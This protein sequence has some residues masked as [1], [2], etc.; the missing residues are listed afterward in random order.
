LK[1]IA[2]RLLVLFVFASCLFADDLSCGG[3][4]AGTWQ[5]FGTGPY[6]AI[7]HSQN[8]KVLVIFCLDYND[9]IAPPYD[10]KANI[11]PVTPTNVT[12]FAQFGGNYGQG[13]TAAPWAFNGD[14]GVGA[15][16][17]VSLAASPTAYTRYLEAAWLFSNILTAQTHGDLN[18]MIISQVAAWDLFVGSTKIA[19]LRNRISNT[20]SSGRY[21]FRNYAYSTDNY[22]T[23][24]T[25]STMTGLL[26]QNAVNEALIAAQHAVVDQNWYASPF[27]PRWD[28]VTGDPAFAR[29]YGR[30]VQEFLTDPPPV[31]EPASIFLFGTVAA[32]ALVALR[33]KYSL[34]AGR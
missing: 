16:H 15:G 19:D 7:D 6:T 3:T 12:Q 28:L 32:A 17:S 1:A 8:D 22:A 23:A 27:A 9:E 29:A 13:V 25:T 11:R 14:P 18:S 4:W 5:G 26:F 34:S 31:P 24:P 21:T 30:P 20:N 10:W 33:R 2:S